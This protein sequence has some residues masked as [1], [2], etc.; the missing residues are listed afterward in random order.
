MQIKHPLEAQTLKVGSKKESLNYG[1]IAVLFL[2]PVVLLISGVILFLNSSPLP[3]QSHSVKFVPKLEKAISKPQVRNLD[4]IKTAPKLATQKPDL[5]KQA[6]NFFNYV[7]DKNVFSEPA[8]AYANHQFLMDETSKTAFLR[9]DYD[10]SLP[11]SFSG[12]HFKTRNLDLSKLKYMSF[13][14]KAGEGKPF[15]DRFRIELKNRSSLVRRFSVTPLTHDWQSYRFD[16]DVSQGTDISE[17][18]FLFE[19]TK[20]GPGAVKGT[21]D[22]KNLTVE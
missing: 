1:L 13:S 3:P 21:V 20:V 8:G 22:F 17:V 16:F 2:L 9:M 18:V 19:N 7:F 10:V 6:G 11:N 15:P 5:A 4:L 14:V 12:V